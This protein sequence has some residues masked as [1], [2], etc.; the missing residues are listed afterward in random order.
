[1]FNLVN[2]N[3]EKFRVLQEYSNF[4]RLEREDGKEP[5]VSKRNFKA[6]FKKA[7]K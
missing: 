1:M 4:M 5:I 2:S 6:N 3:G 7:S